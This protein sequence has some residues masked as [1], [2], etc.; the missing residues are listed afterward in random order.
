VEAFFL[1]TPRRGDDGLLDCIH[2]HPL[3]YM[4]LAFNLKLP[5]IVLDNEGLVA[6]DL[7]WIRHHIEVL[8]D[9]EDLVGSGVSRVL[10]VA[11]VLVGDDQ[12]LV[13]PHAAALAPVAQETPET[14]RGFEAYLC[15][16]L[17][18]PPDLFLIQP[19]LNRFTPSS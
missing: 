17:Y 2:P 1:G 4:I 12:P 16:C 11:D 3:L 15:S 14:V 7:F 9:E 18:L 13:G 5:R 10:E 8:V 6:L 19:S